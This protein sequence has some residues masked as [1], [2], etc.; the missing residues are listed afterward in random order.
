M[1]LEE[2]TDTNGND[3]EITNNLTA[4]LEINI[5]NSLTIKI[6]NHT[7]KIFTC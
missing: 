2:A 5:V 3:R 4:N 6:W 1:S 7:S